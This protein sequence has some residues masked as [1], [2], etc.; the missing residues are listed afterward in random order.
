MGTSAT[1]LERLVVRLVGDGLD[2]QQT[3]E[4]A[5][6]E[7]QEAAA[8][9]TAVTT[10]A[11]QAVAQASESTT[12]AVVANE[13]E[14]VQA[15]LEAAWAKRAIADDLSVDLADASRDVAQA[16][17]EEAQAMQEAAALTRAMRTPQ[18]QYNDEVERLNKLK[19]HLSVE[20]YN[21]AL[22]AAGEA[23]P[24]SQ[25]AAREYAAALQEAKQVTEAVKTP[26]ER[27][28]EEVDRL[29]RLKPHLTQQ[30]YNRALKAAGAALPESIEAAQEWNKAQ[31]QGKAITE[32]LRTPAEQ[33]RAKLAEINSLHKQGHIDAQTHGRAVAALSK[34][35]A[36]AGQRLQQAGQAIT[37]AGRSMQM[38][39]AI[40]TFSLTLPIVGAGAGMVKLASDA[41]ETASKFSVVF[42]DIKG[43]A[44]DAAENLDKSYGM[45]AHGARTLLANTGDLLVGFGFSQQAALD[46]STQVQQLAA[47]LA[48]FTNI[49]GGAEQASEA[50]TKA[51]LGERE[52][53][54]A[55]GIAILDEDV[56]RQ[57]AINHAKGMR[58]ESER[59]AKA[60]ATLVLAQQQSANAIGDYARTQD[61]FA[62]QFREFKADVVDL[63]IQFG[64]LLLPYA[65]EVLGWFRDGVAWVSGLSAGWKTVIAV[66]A[67]MVA[68]L[69]PLVGVLG[70][71]L[72]AVGGVVSIVG[73][74]VTVGW[75][76]VLIGAAIAAGLALLAAEA[77]AVAAAIAGLVYMVVGAEGMASMWESAKASAISFFSTV[78][79]WLSNFRTNM[80]ILMDWLPNHWNEV[81][82]DMGTAYITAFRN[83]V[84]NTGTLL[85][86]A[87][88]LFVAF[89]GWLS[90]MWSQV[91]T[92]DTL[93]ALVS[94]LAK[95][96]TI[97]G[98][99]VANAWEA[100]KSMFTGK[101]LDPSEFMKGISQDFAKGMQSTNFLST[102]TDILREDMQ[103]L[104]GPL[105]GFQS[106]ITDAPQFVYD[107]GVEMGEALAD[108]VQDGA[109]QG[110]GPAYDPE[111]DKLLAD[112]DELRLKLE[113]QVET[114]GKA[115]YALQRWQLAQ[116]GA[117]DEQLAAT[118]ALHAQ[119]A[120]MKQGDVVKKLQDEVAAFG[121]TSREATIMKMAM[122]G[123]TVA[124]IEQARALDAQLTALEKFAK[125][126]D[127]AKQ[128]TEKFRSPTDKLAESQAELKSMLD[129]GLISLDVY[130]RAMKDAEEEFNK[131][132]KITFKADGL[133]AVE[134]DTVAALERLQQYDALRPGGPGTALPTAPAQVA[135]PG[136]PPLAPAPGGPA[137]AVVA[138]A[139]G[140]P[141][142]AEDKE[143]ASMLFFLE[144]IAANTKNTV[145]LA[146]LED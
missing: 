65:K 123:A 58:F 35:Y 20:T 145:Q 55:L 135:G 8:T 38:T 25:Q 79:G 99:W 61:S 96:S 28:N 37:N 67:A 77:V 9:I 92:V 133:D 59:Q 70:T 83:M 27:Y 74:F 12:A 47:D 16:M 63:A 44:Q 118:D 24:E 146:Y 56:K 48:S 122:E 93:K 106:S 75:E 97:L 117:T 126:E 64:Q 111:T 73:F 11:E 14:Q 95:M 29:N 88:R 131:E 53:A 103:K 139:Q 42:R 109:K 10:A 5:V 72:V 71:V 127:K 4:E 140:G 54:K 101:K 134:Q 19:P 104:K 91:F 41:E 84:H 114:Y 50:L 132:M 142:P 137:G 94:G 143:K 21:R 129:A 105:D 136:A 69:G 138:A 87:F 2:Y 57:V 51:L 6:A 102:A 33:Y 66:V 7:T 89:Q 23:L 115:E 43:S 144:Q 45:S 82:A 124:Q 30:A 98:T 46:M 90:N 116:R 125:M 32:Q 34:E 31:Q 80:G 120:A 100:F 15:M 40:M 110:G 49:E 68:A 81:V 112:I 26:Q 62:N 119:L 76:M 3:L 128:V 39:G 85:G 60:Y 13:E 108:G 130:S 78:V 141:G 52:M 121:L 36:V 1:E 107:K 86:T 17:D 18:E 113:G 22:K